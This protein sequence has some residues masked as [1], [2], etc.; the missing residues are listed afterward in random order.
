MEIQEILFPFTAT[1]F[2]VGVYERHG[3]IRT[4]VGKILLQPSQGL[5]PVFKIFDFFY[6][7][8]CAPSK[9]F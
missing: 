9:N 6:S 1:S 2:A 4:D 5:V 7:F 8:E 3:P